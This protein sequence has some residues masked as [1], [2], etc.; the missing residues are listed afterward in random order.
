MK[1]VKFYATWCQ[2]C[3]TVQRMIN[4]SMA[5]YPNA[6]IESV[7]IGEDIQLATKYRVRNVPTCILMTDDGEEVQR[8]VGIPSVSALHDLMQQASNSA[9]KLDE[10]AEADDDDAE[11][12]LE[13]DD[14]AVLNLSDTVFKKF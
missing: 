13:N 6:A 7:D 12:V 5:D 2:P 14:S 4:D 3:K 8:C 9:P 10:A 1:L 11:D